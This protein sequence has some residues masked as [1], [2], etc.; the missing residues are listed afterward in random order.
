MHLLLIQLYN[1]IPGT[2]IGLLCTVDILASL[3]LMELSH[4]GFH[5]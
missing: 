2:L 3:L 4:C 5:S 1:S